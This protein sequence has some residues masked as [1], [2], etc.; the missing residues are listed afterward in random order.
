LEVDEGREEGLEQVVHGLVPPVVP[1]A[2]LD[3]RLSPHGQVYEDLG[4]I[5]I[6]PSANQRYQR[7]FTLNW[8]HLVVDPFGVI[9]ELMFFLLLFPLT[10]LNTVIV[11]NTNNNLRA[12][13][14]TVTSQGELIKF[15][16]IT[17][18]MS[19]DTKRGG[20][21]AFWDD[22]EVLEETIYQNKNYRTRFG[23][24][25]HRFQDLR[26]NLAMC[27]VP[28]DVVCIYINSMIIYYMNR[29][30]IFGIQ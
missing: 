29:M 8:G 16:G 21:T 19:L 7:G 5:N 22:D 14:K 4:D 17:L 18:A 3:E 15:L 9:K 6:D 11:E 30:L 27:G 1:A 2:V 23:M 12:K 24:T 26:A 10:F 25:R 28:N 20:V 13:Q